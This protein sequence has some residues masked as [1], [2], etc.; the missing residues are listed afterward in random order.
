MTNPSEN[1]DDWAEL[2][3]EL[4]HDKPAAP[5]LPATEAAADDDF[6]EGA[7]ETDEFDEGLEAGAESE[8]EPNGESGTD[9]GPPGTGRKRRR[10]RRRRRKGGVQP[11][12]AVAGATEDDGA[13]EAETTDANEEESAD[14]DLEPVV[15]GDYQDE[16]EDATDT[17]V[18]S[19]DAEADEDAGGELLRELI[20]NWNVPSWDDVVG[21]LYRPER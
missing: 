10:R 8:S 5:P 17:D 21:G 7:S 19:R 15:E 11:V 2:A 16:A 20:A 12:G 1:D 13:D 18:S 4:A 9:E 3:R 14:G 6:S